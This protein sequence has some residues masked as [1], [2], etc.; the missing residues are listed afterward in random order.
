MLLFVVNYQQ[1]LSSYD[2]LKNADVE[3][4]VLNQPK[5]FLA[6]Q[7]LLKHISQ[8]PWKYHMILHFGLCWGKDKSDIGNIY[9]IDRTFLYHKEILDNQRFRHWYYHLSGIESRHIVSK[10]TMWQHGQDLYDFAS[11]YDLE[12]FWVAQVSQQTL[13]PI[14][15]IKWV[16]DTNDLAVIHMSIQDEIDFLLNPDQ[17]RSKKSLIMGEL[18]QNIKV[19]TH[20]FQDYYVN[21]FSPFYH[22]Y[23]SDAALRKSLIT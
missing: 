5:W 17:K 12:T 19:I 22:H 7:K 3:I 23:L 6:G 9:K 21:E 8:F 14:F 18:G 10:W 11:I 13:T 4:L 20:K 16:S 2:F 1:E 15:S